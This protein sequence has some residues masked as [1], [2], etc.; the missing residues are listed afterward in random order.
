MGGKPDRTLP[1]QNVSLNYSAGNMEL[2]G[3]GEAERLTAVPVTEDFF[4][5]LGAE[6]AIGRSFTK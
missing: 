1:P 5:P 6:P 4:A 3:T 2:T